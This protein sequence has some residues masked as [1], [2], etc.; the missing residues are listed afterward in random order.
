MNLNHCPNFGG[1]YKAPKTIG[2][3]FGSEDELLEGILKN[4]SYVHHK[5]LL[6]LA[7]HHQYQRLKIRFVLYPFSFVFLL[8]GQQKFH[9][10]LETLDTKEATYVWHLSKEISQFKNELEL[11]NQK[12][13]R[14]RYN[15]RQSFLETKSKNFSKIIHDYSEDKKGFYKWKNALEERLI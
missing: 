3:F 5:Q 1:N 7:K 14:I 15:G 13:N 4:S 9:I 11:I 2:S 12:M 6:Y 10:I 8:E